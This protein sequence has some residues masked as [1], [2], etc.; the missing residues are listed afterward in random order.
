MEERV[1]R[2]QPQLF[3]FAASVIGGGSDGSGLGGSQGEEETIIALLGNLSK[4]DAN[5]KF[6]L[7]EIPHR[8][9]T[10]PVRKRSFDA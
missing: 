10:N 1:S 3:C 4:E 5:K 6:H 8:F 9:S 2:H 7:E